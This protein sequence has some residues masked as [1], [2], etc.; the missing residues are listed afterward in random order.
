MNTV[1]KIDAKNNINQISDL[2]IT[3][4]FYG[5]VAI[6]ISKIK[7]KIITDIDIILNEI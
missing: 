3:N 5:K 7:A 4:K 1:C 2:N 6:K